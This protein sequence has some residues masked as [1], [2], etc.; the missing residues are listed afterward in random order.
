MS[1]SEKSAVKSILAMHRTYAELDEYLE[2]ELREAGYAGVDIQKNPIGSR[3][4][5]FVTRPG[6]AIGRR[7]TGI[8][9]LTERVAA[10]FALPNPQIAVS[11][12]EAPELNP[13]IMAARTAQIVSRGT[14]FRR[15]ATWTMNSIMAAGASG[16]EIGVAGKLRS[17]R[18]HSEKYRMGVVPKSGEASKQVVREA[19]TDVLLK[20]G[21]YGIQVKIALRGSMPPMV[22]YIEQPA[23]VPQAP[24]APQAP[25]TAA[26]PSPAPAPQEPVPEK[27][28]AQQPVQTEVK[29]SAATKTAK[30]RRRQP[31]AAPAPEPVPEPQAEPVPEPQ[32]ETKTEELAPPRTEE[33]AETS[34]QPT[35]ENAE[36]IEVTE[37]STDVSQEPEVE[38]ELNDTIEPAAVETVEQIAKSESKES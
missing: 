30:P 36:A 35:T 8:K 19:T 13:R 3:I 2:K 33:S 25:Q 11:E 17:D 5:V 7:G 22:E 4:T 12:V 21:L 37:G 29:P 20:L 10:K 23:E 31:K 26:A 1:V 18:S 24:Q 32:A 34:E 38:A 6:L 9:D 28:E 14:A 27:V 16:V 15:A